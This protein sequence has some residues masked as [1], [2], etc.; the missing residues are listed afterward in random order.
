MSNKFTEFVSKVK[1]TFSDFRD[2]FPE[3]HKATMQLL[4]GTKVAGQNPTLPAPQSLNLPRLS[5]AN[6][7][8]ATTDKPLAEAYGVTG[9]QRYGG[10][11]QEEYLLELQ[12]RNG[13][14]KFDEM[15]R[16]DSQVF[17]SIMRGNNKLKSA[18][19]FVEPTNKK[20]KQAGE[21]A[22]FLHKA[23]FNYTNKC[24]LDT[25]NEILSFRHIGFSVFEPTY[26][27]ENIIGFGDM[28]VVASLGWRNPKTIW[29]WF[30]KN[31]ELYSVRQIS[32]GDEYRYVDIPA[33]Y[34]VQKGKDGKNNFMSW[35]QLIVFTNLL[36]GNGFEGISLLRP[37]YGEYKRKDTYHKT[38]ALGIENNARGITNVTV[39]ETQIGTALDE[40]MDAILNRATVTNVPW[41]KF[42]KG[43][44]VK[45]EKTDYQAEPV[46][47]SILMA[48]A[49]ISKV[50]QTESSELGMTSQGSG[51]RALGDSKGAEH[52][53][54][55]KNEAIYI[56]EKLSQIL[57][58]LEI[59]N[60]G[61]QKDYCKLSFIGID[62]KPNFED[63]KKLQT[64]VDAGFIDATNKTIR[65]YVNEHFDIPSGEEIQDAESDTEPSDKSSDKT[66][67]KLSDIKQEVK[68][69]GD[70]IKKVEDLTAKGTP[71]KTMFAIFES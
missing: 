48:D 60:F 1:K 12:G 70:T 8:Q 7:E 64:L 71:P 38:N 27:I 28:L 16:S 44:D 31:E 26:K 25:L 3:T 15:F 18:K 62:S 22:K 35:E 51:S 30:V 65:A 53:E 46:M 50:T 9:T 56:C 63:A 45:F 21:R 32:Y 39:P 49:S 37:M 66:L 10:F 69:H 68:E 42:L 55:I 47:R 61:E 14:Y 19:Y 13:V 11:S 41:R 43:W 6:G 4:E 59:Y 20:D 57:K 2:G 23:L 29:Q 40:K 58:Y 54:A 33:S 52:D 5:T 67:D 24:W 17:T 34:M 36:Y